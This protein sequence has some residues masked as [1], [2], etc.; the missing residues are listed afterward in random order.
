MELRMTT[1]GMKSRSDLREFA[2]IKITNILHRFEDRIQDVAV[3]LQDVTGPKKKGVD[4][5]CRIEIR[6]KTGGTILI[7]ELDAAMPAAIA[8]ALDR[9]KAAL[10]RQVNKAKRGVGHG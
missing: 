1:R 2:E 10:S 5:R 7:D 3:L 9:C 6:M 8:L 4:Q